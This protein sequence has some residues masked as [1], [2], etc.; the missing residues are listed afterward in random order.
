[1]NSGV[2]IAFW[3]LTLSIFSVNDLMTQSE[4]A[5]LAEFE[6]NSIFGTKKSEPENVYCLL[7]SGFFRTPRSNEAD[8]LVTEWLRKHPEAVVYPVS[9]ISPI[10]E[11]VNSKMIY[12]LVV[13]GTDTLNNY[14]VRKGCYPGGT[15]IRPRTIEEMS[16]EDKKIWSDKD[17][18]TNVYMKKDSYNQYIE[19]IR[20]AEL[21][22][23]KNGMGIWN[24]D[25]L[26]GKE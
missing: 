6:F 16:E 13:Q 22:A 3:V 25:F 19:Q 11:S 17:M 26:K 2:K 4:K 23:R 18:E 1:M 15:M 12:C 20:Q 7:G 21:Y 9:S 5:K 10:T 8:S 24:E 14:V